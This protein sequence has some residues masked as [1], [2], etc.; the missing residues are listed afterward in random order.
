MRLTDGQTDTFLIATPRWHSIQ[1]GK[2]RLPVVGGRLSTSQRGYI[3]HVFRVLVYYTGLCC[4]MGTSRD[5]P[6]TAG[7]LSLLLVVQPFCLLG[8]A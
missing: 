5:L 6:H 1:R 2:K 4:C 8:L 7:H 3:S